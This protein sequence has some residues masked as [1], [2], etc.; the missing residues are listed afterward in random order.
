MSETRFWPSNG[1][2]SVEFC[3]ACGGKEAD[4][5][6]DKLKD[7]IF[8]SA[9]DSDWKLRSCRTCHSAFL[10][11]RPTPET[12][13][14]AYGQYYTHTPSGSP[15]KNG[16]RK[17]S[18]MGRIARASVN[19]YRNIRFKTNISPSNRLGGFLVMLFRPVA[20]YFD[21]KARYIWRPARGINNL[22][23]VGAGNGEFLKFAKTMGWNAVGL[24][25]D[26]KAVAVA[27]SDGL[28]MR[29]GSLDLFAS[30][31]TEFDFITVSHVI[32]HVYDPVKLLADCKRL[33]KPGGQL[34]LETPNINAKGH[35][36][37]QENWRGLE[38]PRHLVL[39]SQKAL[40][41]ALAKMGFEEIRYHNRG[42]NTVF[43]YRES[44]LIAKNERIG[45]SRVSPTFSPRYLMDFIHEYA[46]GES[47][48]FL[49]VTARRSEE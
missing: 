8:G 47:R 10:D 33:L 1:F 15:K 46:F 32:E 27:K 29:L 35:Q 37:F 20:L 25:N 34:W 31:E 36:R 44:E 26:P 17:A 19:G 45:A 4:I 2:E 43:T 40:T 49:T 48:E 11:P 23:D 12:L 16:A 21:A 41:E 3:P 39:F 13:H 6:H 30:Q 7:R 38:P 9:P 42:L 28:D 22:L 14:I 18:Y 24:D 5:L